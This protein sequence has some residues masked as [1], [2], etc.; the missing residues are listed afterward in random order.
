[1]T[2]FFST[3]LSQCAVTQ[4]LPSLRA[5]VEKKR[6]HKN[7]TYMMDNNIIK[8]L[9]QQVYVESFGSLFGLRHLSEASRTEDS[10]KSMTT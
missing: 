1:M 6:T 10:N 2:F 5:L 7:G 3:V 4:R 8:D 9:S